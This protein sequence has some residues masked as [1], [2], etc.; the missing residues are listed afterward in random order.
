MP[1]R[2]RMYVAGVPYHVVRRGNNREACFFAPEDY[3]AYLEAR[4]WRGM[5]SASVRMC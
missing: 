3:Q 1:R 4:F 5:V 2:A